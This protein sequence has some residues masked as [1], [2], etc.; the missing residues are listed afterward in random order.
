MFGGHWGWSTAKVRRWEEGASN[1]GLYHQQAI[2]DLLGVAWDERERVGFAVPEP[3]PE[4]EAALALRA[5]GAHGR[6]GGHRSPEQGRQHEPRAIP[7]RWRGCDRDPGNRAAPVSRLGPRGKGAFDPGS[8]RTIADALSSTYDT[9]KC[10]D[11]LGPARLHLWQVVGSLYQVTRSERG[12][13]LAVG[14]DMA[15]LC[16][17]LTRSSGTIGD[18]HAYF[19]CARGSSNPGHPWRACERWTSG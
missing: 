1:P 4:P 18:A 2:C 6:I 5:G 17:W 13:L 14:V 19:A 15:C 16:G 10:G 7:V 11:L 12:E 9:V 8:V 3:A